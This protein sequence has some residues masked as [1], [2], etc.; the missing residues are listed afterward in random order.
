MPMGYIVPLFNI[1][2]RFIFFKQKKL[3]VWYSYFNIKPGLICFHEE[4]KH[5]HAHSLRGI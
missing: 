5:N 4:T 1:Y 3:S 2:L